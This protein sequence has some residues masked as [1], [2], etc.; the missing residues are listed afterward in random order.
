MVQAV[1]EHLTQPLNQEVL[2][3]LLHFHCGI[4]LA[5]E[6]SIHCLQVGS[7]E[8]QLNDI[9]QPFSAIALI[10]GGQKPFC[11]PH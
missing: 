3:F 2:R 9:H 5:I 4:M 8:Q 7:G 11:Q 1:V 6:V 10:D